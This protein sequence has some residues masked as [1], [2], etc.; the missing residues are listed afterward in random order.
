MNIKPAILPHSFEEITEKLSRIEG[1][2]S[3]VQIDICDGVFGREK[4]WLP[5]GTEVLPTGFTYEFDVMVNDWKVYIPNCI[6]LGVTSIVAHVDMFTDEDIATLVG[7]VASHSISLGIA[8]SNDKNIDFHAD[9]FRK[10]R[11]LYPHVFI[12]VMGILNIGEQGQLFDENVPARV[13][14]I[15]Q[16]F[17]DV[18]VQV[19]GGITPETAKLVINDGADTVVVGSYIFGR[20]DAGEALERLN[21]AVGVKMI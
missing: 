4:T 3:S 17:G 7:M 2:V 10:V 14:A 12:Q 6:S 1:V 13:K 15:K 8:V 11:E 21:A 20:D 18:S 9:M 16:I 19:D 5:S